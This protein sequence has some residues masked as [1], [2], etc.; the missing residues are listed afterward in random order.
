MIYLDASVALARLFAEDTVPPVDFW[1]QEL[2]SSRLL[3][4]EVWNRVYARNWQKDHGEAV[5]ELLDGVELVELSWT[6]LERALEPFPLHVRT[7]DA[8]HLATVHYLCSHRERVEFVTYDSR[9]AAAARALDI[10]LR[11]L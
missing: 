6:A 3:E 2:V 8:L 4:Y 5:R 1:E 11:V 7:L 9:L 10:P